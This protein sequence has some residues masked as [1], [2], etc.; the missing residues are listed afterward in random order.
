MMC[1][2]TNTALLA[3]AAAIAQ[4][5]AGGHFMGGY[6]P[7]YAEKFGS[8][9][10]QARAPAF[11]PSKARAPQPVAQ[12]QSTEGFSPEQL[13]F[14][15]RTGKLQKSSSASYSAPAQVNDGGYSPEQLAFLERTGKLNKASSSAG[16]SSSDSYSARPSYSSSFSQM[17]GSQSGGFMPGYA[18]V[19]A[20]TFG[21]APSMEL[22]ATEAS[23]NFISI[24]AAALMGSIVGFA[25][26][27]YV[28]RSRRSAKFGEPL[29]N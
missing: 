19:Y 22:D 3:F 9:V 18:P 14:L 12:V 11:Y 24:C 6:A 25:V 21:N 28:V 16:Y 7:G 10:Q 29:L 5:Q 17:S 8:S 26:T 1:S 23:P 27:F 2:A 13:A 15:E 20:P 4:V